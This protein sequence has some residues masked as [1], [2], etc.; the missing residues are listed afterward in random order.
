MPIPKAALRF[1]RDAFPQAG[2]EFCQLRG[3]GKTEIGLG[4]GAFTAFF[5][6]QRHIHEHSLGVADKL[7]S[8]ACERYPRLLPRQIEFCRIHYRRRIGAKRG[9]RISYEGLGPRPG[10]SSPGHRLDLAQNRLHLGGEKDLG[11][12][13]ALGDVIPFQNPVATIEEVDPSRRGA[14]KIGDH[15]HQRAAAHVA[16]A[17]MQTQLFRS[18]HHRGLEEVG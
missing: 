6:A 4:D 17:Q 10:D 7:W 1:L 5:D 15:F 2:N 9:K 12:A 14:G 3:G 8:E 18:Q 16:P 13:L 11:D